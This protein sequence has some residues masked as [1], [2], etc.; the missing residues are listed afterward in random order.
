M[1]A[2][3]WFRLWSM[4]IS[5]RRLW[6]VMEGA[7]IIV[8]V[9]PNGSGKSLVMV[10]GMLPTLDGRAWHCFDVEHKHHKVF[11]DHAAA[12]P[13][14]DY[15]AFL[16][17]ACGSVSEV[18]AVVADGVICA[19]GG[20]LVVAASSGDRLVYSTV[21]LTLTKGVP[22]PLYRP[23][24]DYQQ[25]L[26][27]EHADV[28]FDEVAG[29]SDA[30]GSASMP[31][32]VVNWQHQLRKR[33]IRQRVTTPAYARCSLPIRQVAQVV[34]E[35]RSF[36]PVRVAG[37]LWRP[38]RII[39]A[40]AYDAWSFEDFI[41]ADGQRGKLRPMAKGLIWVPKSRALDT[42]NSFGQVLQLGHVTEGGMC[43]TCGGS[44]AR[45]KCGCTEDLSELPPD[46][47]AV[48]TII[49]ASGARVRKAVRA[50]S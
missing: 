18:A 26:L 30:S 22:H 8:L 3:L 24:T 34:V 37:L 47:V 43:I 2:R 9:G 12:C 19:D 5:S 32:Q 13:D 35:C 28:L 49:G 31:V 44:R 41:A 48:E 39:F 17:Y 4:V 38:R 21:P 15:R 6:E 27:I 11:S 7:G 14:C 1:L 10:E 45:P 23:L 42:Y 33:D 20:E 16:A 40:T 50:A 46:L 25:L 29:I 36:A